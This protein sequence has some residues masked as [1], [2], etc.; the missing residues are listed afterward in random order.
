MDKNNDDIKGW[1]DICTIQHGNLHH[2]MLLN[3][4]KSVLHSWKEKQ[5]SELSQIGRPRKI[6]HDSV[7]SP[8]SIKTYMCACG[9]KWTVRRANWNI[10]LCSI[11][12]YTIY[13]FWRRLCRSRR[14]APRLN[15]LSMAFRAIFLLS[16]STSLSSLFSRGYCFSGAGSM[17][18]HS[19]TLMIWHFRQNLAYKKSYWS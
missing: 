18:A 1:R 3:P 19:S 9:R 6:D 16:V 10:Q 7:H 14:T 15:G 5:G 12:V 13:V 11:R 17:K 2:C 8:R 4:S